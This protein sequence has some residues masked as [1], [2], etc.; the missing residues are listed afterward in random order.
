VLKYMGRCVQN[1][2]LLMVLLIWVILAVVLALLLV[3]SG[4]RLMWLRSY[5]IWVSVLLVLA[6]ILQW[7][8]DER[9]E[10]VWFVSEAWRW[11][12]VGLCLAIVLFLR[13]VKIRKKVVRGDWVCCLLLLLVFITRAWQVDEQPID[14]DEYASIQAVLSIAETGK[15][16][17]ADDIWYSRSPLYHYG[18]AA[19]V[20][21]FGPN[22]WSLRLYSV[23]LSVATGL[24]M[25]MLAKRYFKDTW[26]AALAVLIFA[27]HP[28]LIFSGH[29][30]R[31]YQQ[32]QFKGFS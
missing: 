24:V 30:A 13:F 22:L 8:F 28:F 23:M 17:I 2:G 16:E 14:D 32:Q 5:A 31:F 25:W 26:L 18:A 29:I 19:V 7:S 27:L 11:W 4:K 20:V 21:V 1:T 3:L 6:V 12:V 9:S 15:P 10:V